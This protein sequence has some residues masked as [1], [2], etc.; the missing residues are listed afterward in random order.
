M[1]SL[2]MAIKLQKHQNDFFINDA[3][4]LSIN[5]IHL[6]ITTNTKFQYSVEIIAPVFQLSKVKEELLT[7]FVLNQLPYQ[8]FQHVLLKNITI[9]LIH[10]I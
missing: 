4:S 10:E 1:K 2:K 6:S 5:K 7:L 9:I 8:A 3:S